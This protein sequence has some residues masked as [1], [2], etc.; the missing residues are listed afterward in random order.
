MDGLA[1]RSGRP[2]W[3]LCD[4]EPVYAVLHEPGERRQTN[5]AV[6]IL[7]TFGWDNDCSYRPRREWAVALARAGFTA[8][9]IDLPG[10]DDSV[11]SPLAPGRYQS[12]LD[13]VADC[14]QWLRESSGCDRVAAVGIG[15]GGLLAYEAASAGAAIDDLILWGVPA[16]GRAYLRELRAYADIVAAGLGETRDADRDDGA[17]PIGGHAMA[18]ETATAINELRLDE[19]TLP[20]A[21]Q[22]RVLLVERDAHGV[23][24]R[25]SAHLS[26]QGVE[27]TVLPSSTDYESLMAIAELDLVPE[28]TIARSIEW[29]ATA[30]TVS[31]DHPKRGATPKVADVI[32]FQHSGRLIRERLTSVE[33]PHGLLSGIISEPAERAAASFCVV[34]VNA[35]ALR[36]TGPNR[37]MPRIA[38]DAAAAGL[39]AARFDRPGLGD[40]E[41]R[42][43]K[44]T[45]RSPADEGLMIATMRDIHDHLEAEQ[46]ASR[47]ISVGIC[48]GA[49]AAMRTALEDRRTVACI[50]ANLTLFKWTPHH[51]VL[52]QSAPVD[53]EEVR[54]AS[55]PNQSETL[56]RRA[57]TVTVKVLKE[58]KL[59]WLLKHRGELLAARRTLDQLYERETR[60]VLVFSEHEAMYRTLTTAGIVSRIGRWP[61]TSLEILPT[62]DHELRPLWVQ[63]QVLACVDSV[64]SEFA[65]PAAP[66]AA[67]GAPVV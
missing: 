67:D 34:S 50:L 23:D 55:T 12:W 21:E 24:Q 19:L 36:R 47:F 6:L 59:P 33:T 30:P 7:P 18:A 62:R 45:E 1:D 2:L 20:A 29:L 11:G 31:L 5:T 57:R 3:L 63:D 52:A 17:L 26:D 25:L 9:R 66:T 28:D 40:S 51:A 46:V 38:R 64:L 49:Y 48:S 58:I 60:V 10:A 65:S 56:I 32:T 16:R 4:P 54:Q 42:Y 61:N 14:A 39:A 53:R 13:A 15:L 44:R 8:L 22:R 41:G 43:V 37:I 27:L 35:G